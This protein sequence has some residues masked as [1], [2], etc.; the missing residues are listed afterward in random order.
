MSFGDLSGP[1]SVGFR[2]ESLESTGL[3]YRLF[4]PISTS[5]N[6]NNVTETSSPW[7]I[8]TAYLMSLVHFGL[9][10][11]VSPVFGGLI[12]W[13]LRHPRLP[14]RPHETPLRSY[15]LV[16]FSHGLGGNRMTYAKL[17]S[18]IASHGF[19]VAALEHLDGSASLAHRNKPEEESW[20]PY[21]KPPPTHMD[22]LAFRS[23]QITQRM[24]ELRDVQKALKERDFIDSD[25]VILCGHSFGAASI[26]SL[27]SG[28]DL[29]SY[30]GALAY[31][32]YADPLSD[33]PQV[34]S[35][36]AMSPRILYINNEVFVRKMNQ[37]YLKPLDAG[38]NQV[39]TLKGTLHYCQ[40]D[41]PSVLRNIRWPLS[42]FIR[43]KFD[44]ERDERGFNLSVEAFVAFA[45]RLLKGQQPGDDSFREFIEGNKEEFIKGFSPP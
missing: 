19:V 12:H 39:W 35:N 34:L 4:Y 5:L 6:N 11:N 43:Q 38:V 40:S 1:H 24:E 8:S 2:D 10:R 7:V 15:P 41:V 28:E 3:T 27:L 32:I 20:I 13:I 31:D 29:A 30:L 14:I 42:Y 44:F 18:H 17:A 22:A 16:L 9:G 37:S 45:E 33:R 23:R 26:V 25:K 21:V 36:H